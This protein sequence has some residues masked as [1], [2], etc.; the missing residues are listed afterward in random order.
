MAQ[1]D[2]TETYTYYTKEIST[3]FPQLAYIH[4]VESRIAGNTTIDAPEG[5]TLD[6]IYDIWTP[7]AFLAAGGFTP[8][9]AVEEANARQNTAVVFGRY[10]ISN[11]DLVERIKQGVELAPYN[12][13]TFYL[14]G[15]KE[16]KGY[17]DY[18]KAT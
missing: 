10:F 11:P 2:I 15:P 18:P 1:H 14:L 12:R 7:R 9:S 13:D 6:F 17:T 8:E 5:E 16:T 3:R 4:A